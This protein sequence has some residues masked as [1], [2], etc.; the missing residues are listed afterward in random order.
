MIRDSQS[1]VDEMLAHDLWRSKER[2]LQVE[3]VRPCRIDG[4]EGVFLVGRERAPSKEGERLLVNKVL[5]PVKGK[6]RHPYQ[7]PSRG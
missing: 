4:R 5:H 6:D 2:G 1:D 7:C 3:G